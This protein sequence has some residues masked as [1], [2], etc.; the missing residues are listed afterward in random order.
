MRI[1]L[2]GTFT[3]RYDDGTTATPSA[4]KR[5][6]LLAALAVRLHRVVP[7]D[8]LIELVW[9]GSP[10]PTARAALQ[11]HVTALRRLLDDRLHLATRGTGYV[12]AG[13]PEQV[14]AAH[15]E[16]LC[17]RAG[18]LL[19]ACPAAEGPPDAPA[20][21]ALPLLRSALDLWRGPALA[22]CGSALLREQAAPGLTD[23]RLRALERL[24]DV[25]CRGGRG[26][27]L[28]AEL[29]EAVSAHPSHQRLAAR[30]LTCLEQAGRRDEALAPPRRAPA[31]GAGP[32]VRPSTGPAGAVPRMRPVPAQLPRGDRRFVGRAADL[33][34]LD[35]AVAGRAGGPV[36][37]TGPAG[38]GKT[39]LVQH[40]A[41]RAADRFPDGVLYADLRGFDRAEPRDPAEVLT[42]FL[43][44]L[45]ADTPPSA[46]LDRR[47]RRYRELL[48]DRR[49]LIVL[50]NAHSAEQVAPLLPGPGPEHPARPRGAPAAASV[51][52]VT[53]RDRLRELS[54]RD[55]S[56]PIPLDGL[57]PADARELL[58][59]AWEP[60]PVDAE[61]EAATAL[62]AH[63]DHLPL[64]LRTAA[65]R[66][67]GRPGRALHDLAAEL[68][69]EQL[70][71]AALSG[72][73]SVPLGV[74]AALD[75]SL[76]ALPPAAAQT[77]ALL[78]LHP[79]TAI[80]VPTA[81]VLTD[82]SPAAVRA[83]LAR[84]EAVHLVEEDGPGRYT[85]RGLVR[86]H[87]ARLAADL[88][89]GRQRAAVERMTDHYLTATAA[90]CTALGIEDGPPADTP[91]ASG[92]PGGPAP[93]GAPPGGHPTAPPTPAPGPHDVAEPARAA[94]WFRREAGTVHA[95]VLSAVHHGRTAA[96]W[97]LAHRAGL[98]HETVEPGGPQRRAVAEAGLRAARTSA[99]PA[100]VARLATDLAAAHAAR[101]EPRAAAEHLDQ[102]LAAAGRAADP[103]LSA[104]C[105]TRVAV[106]LQGSGLAEHAVP[107]LAGVAADARARADHR[108]LARS[109]AHLADALIATGAPG[110]A[111]AHADEA[112]HLLATTQGP[113]EQISAA[114]SRARALEAL[115]R[116]GAAL[117]SARLALALSRV[118]GDPRTRSRSHLLIADLLHAL[119]RTAEAEAARRAAEATAT[120][121]R[122]SEES[123]G[124][125]R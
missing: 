120:V 13:D 107:I 35:E 93:A 117:D 99:D 10:P 121:R 42:S 40:W 57:T 58:A 71:L 9:E 100:A 54:D 30:L 105:R 115:G 1:D 6:A 74:T 70:R 51:T 110:Q 88:T 19:P 27:E 113:A 85:R 16:R 32:A 109:L 61:P 22:D 60:E 29:T 98:L 123:C 45:D 15:F 75:L 73:G 91:S 67:A 77:F 52:V 37:V 84:L 119:G 48:A 96:A 79:G 50:D 82:T 31:G 108:L 36:L 28:V 90:A 56:L 55:G 17:D 25:L 47:T 97:Q 76:R 49:I 69:D 7:A 3:V 125:G 8:E 66:L 46:P 118:G 106:A 124:P 53:S 38:V 24:A 111:L 12:L 23:L 20:D 4:P 63:C 11:G 104:R 21:P 34:R 41:R 89:H 43:T 65:A 44:A 114:H 18:V 95:L 102:A 72:T 86:L 83:E 33:V 92:R 78:G 68:A 26:G 101:G 2:L 94:A 81:A 5:R 103:V 116:P 112:L 59:R 64:A 80:D 39:A 87:S 14:D 122:P 62:A